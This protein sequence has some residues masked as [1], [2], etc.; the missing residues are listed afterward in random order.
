MSPK[1]GIYVCKMP[2]VMFDFHRKK[3]PKTQF[4]TFLV[5]GVQL[6]FIQSL[7]FV[8]RKSSI[9]VFVCISCD[10]G[11]ILLCGIIN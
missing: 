5:V 7:T 6:K 2:T 10:L 8:Y 4:Y 11:H 1:P 9:Y 3:T